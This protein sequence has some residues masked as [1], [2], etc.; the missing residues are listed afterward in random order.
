MSGQG[1]ELG[2]WD[3]QYYE[4]QKTKVLMEDCS[5]VAGVVHA[6]REVRMTERERERGGGGG[7]GLWENVGTCALIFLQISQLI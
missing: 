4:V 3:C 1:S 6:R 5:H 2:R 7:G